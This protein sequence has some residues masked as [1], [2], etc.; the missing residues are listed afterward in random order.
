MIYTLTFHSVLNLGAALQTYA[1]QAYI[2][3]KGLATEVLDYSPY[4]LVWRNCRPSKSL[5]RSIDKYKRY[6]QFSKFRNDYIDL[7]SRKIRNVSGLKFLTD[8]DVVVC[9][10][11]QIWNAKI[12]NGVPD[13]VFYLKGNLASTKVAYAASAGGHLITEWHSEYQSAVSDFKHIGT[14][15]ESLALN[16]NSFVPDRRALQ[17]VDPTLLIEDYDMLTAGFKAPEGEYIASYEVSDDSTRARYDQQI[18]RLKDKLKLPVYH[19]GAKKISSADYNLLNIGPCE[20]LS[21]IKNAKLVCTN[22]F[23]GTALSLNFSKPF[24]SFMHLDREKNVRVQSLLSRIQLE[25]KFHRLQDDL[26]E[27]DLFQEYDR[28]PLNAF[29]KQSREFLDIAIGL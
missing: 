8:S 6:V 4:Y 5:L 16:V 3:K 20:W 23:H 24:V 26:S 7:S 29:V 27:E 13:D 28:G 17:V 11:D 25:N 21:F 10:S 2:K 15:E 9:G 1:L 12:T 14:R 19:L 22:S 18:G